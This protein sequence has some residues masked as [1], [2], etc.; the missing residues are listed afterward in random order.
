MNQIKMEQQKKLTTQMTMKN[1]LAEIQ[2]QQK[3]IEWMAQAIKIVVISQQGEENE[4]SSNE[5]KN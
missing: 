2:E 3:I 5:S 1:V 4:G